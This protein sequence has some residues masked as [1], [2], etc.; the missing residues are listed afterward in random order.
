MICKF[1]R[2]REP[3]TPISGQVQ[4]QVLHALLFQGFHSTLKLIYSGMRKAGQFHISNFAVYHISGIQTIYRNLISCNI[5]I[6]KLRYIALINGI[7]IESTD[8]FHHLG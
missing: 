7:H 2:H 5:E 6:K 1:N 8:L 4:N 3:A